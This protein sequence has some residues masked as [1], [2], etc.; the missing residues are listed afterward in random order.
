MK[1][2]KPGI[3]DKKYSKKKKLRM[4]EQICEEECGLL[5]LEKDIDVSYDHYS[6]EV[7]TVYIRE[8]PETTN[9]V[10]HEDVKHIAE[11]I[12]TEVSERW[13]LGIV[14]SRPEMFAWYTGEEEDDLT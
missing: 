2:K 10:T 4:V 8:N 12:R 5:Y 1:D 9:R 7:H 13:H 14:V 11:R 3:K 6:P